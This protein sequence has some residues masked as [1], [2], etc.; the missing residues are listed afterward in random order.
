MAN[1]MLTWWYHLYMNQTPAEKKLESI[2]AKMGVEYRTQHPFLGTRP[3]AIA[4]FYFPKHSLIVEVDDPSHLT[5][6][7]QKKDQERTEALA[8]L[9]LIV[10]RFSNR[11]V[12]RTPTMVASKILSYL[13]KPALAAFSQ[14]GGTPNSPKR[15]R[16][17]AN[18]SNLKR[19]P[20][21]DV[22]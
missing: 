22:L 19:A 3:R 20:L 11:D 7:K 12:L 17:I 2:V 9:G 21:P 4:D 15:K 16:E 8:G 10:I 6:K 5:K 18:R 1:I 13:G 14:S